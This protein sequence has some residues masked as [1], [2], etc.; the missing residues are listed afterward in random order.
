M[1]FM[2]SKEETTVDQFDSMRIP[3]AVTSDVTSREISPFSSGFASAFFSVEDED[4]AAAA[5]AAAVGAAA[6]GVLMLGEW[7]W[8]GGCLSC[9]GS[10]RWRVDRTPQ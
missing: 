2:S 4:A 1:R 10:R 3:S 8:V 9:A 7:G 6:A 5:G